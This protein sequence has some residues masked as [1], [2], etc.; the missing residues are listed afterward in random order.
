MKR[1]QVLTLV[2]C[3]LFAAVLL[4][5]SVIAVGGPP[6]TTYQGRL[7]DGSGNPLEGTHN[8][9]FTIYTAASGGTN[10]WSQVHSSVT[11]GADGLFDVVLGPIPDSVWDEPNRWLGIAVAPDPEMTPRTQF[12]AAPYAFRVRT[13]D[14]ADGGAIDGDVV[15][16]GD[17]MAIRG[18]VYASVTSTYGVYGFASNPVS[19]GT[20]VR[21][22]SNGGPI[23]V[24]V[25]GYAQDGETNTY[26]VEGV[27][28][29][30]GDHHI[31]VHG[32]A[33]NASVW[34]VGVEGSAYNSGGQNYGMYAHGY[35]TGTT[36]YGIYASGEAGTI[37]YGIYASSPLGANN[38]AGWFDGDVHISGTLTGGGL[39]G[40]GGWVDDGTTV[41]LETTTDDVGI[42]ITSPGGKLHVVASGGNKAVFGQSTSGGTGSGGHFEGGEKGVL[43]WTPL[44]N[45][46]KYAVL[47]QCSGSNDLSGF[48]VYGIS[49]S[50]HNTVGVYG[51]GYGGSN[52][53]FGVQ[54]LA[55]A[56]PSPAPTHFGLYAEASEASSI[57]YGIQAKAY[58]P[59]D[60]NYGI[61][62]SASGDA[63]NYA[64]YFDGDVH[65]TG[66]LTGG[67]KAFRIDHPLDPEN[68]YL[69]HSC[70]ESPD[71]KNVYDGVVELDMNGS[72]V[73]ELPDYFEA[74]NRDFRYQ[75]T[76]IG[77]S[78]PNLYI[79]REVSDNR[80]TIAGGA[81]G[82]KVSWQVTGIRKDA[83]AEAN[84]IRPV[85]EK[86]AG[87]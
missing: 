68:K 65:V 57:N 40:I 84:R 17:S 77:A 60:T 25:S 31:G 32:N 74:L 33:S 35:G 4:V 43:G 13:I 71:M 59:A 11:T 21:G 83:L 80:F 24:G 10:L 41:R 34:N 70:V 1:V 23:P 75:L 2:G 49:I 66:T 54:A 20:G 76:A 45:G 47:G 38:W 37:N 58:G 46:Y 5:G 9:T 85:V 48:G 36:N 56:G 44:G 72:T 12:Y 26:G 87:E 14:E 22:H 15:V 16:F 28:A 67:T 51:K 81:P 79:A 82:M 50:G 42:G 3:A 27:A 6:Y 18:Q 29:G 61:Y 73:V 78:A 69:Y 63:I 52:A 30:G 86:P 39:S 64:G 62:A 53:N 8:L 7:T 19:Q 55:D